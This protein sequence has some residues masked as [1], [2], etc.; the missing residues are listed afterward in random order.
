MELLKKENVTA[1]SSQF[2]EKIDTWETVVKKKSELR[3]VY[4]DVTWRVVHLNDA[5]SLYRE[6]KELSHCVSAYVGSCRRGNIKIFSIRMK[7]LMQKEKI[8][9]T[10][11]VDSSSGMVK[12]AR[13]K[14][15]RPLESVEKEILRKWAGQMHYRISSNL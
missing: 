3:D 2:G 14:F 9:A 15:N 7:E 5:E 10:I 12:Q 1:D 4:F 6:G 8:I 13:G 11:E